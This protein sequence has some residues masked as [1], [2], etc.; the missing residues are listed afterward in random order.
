[1]PDA[2][3]VVA[4]IARGRRLASPGT[5]TRPFSDRA[6][7]A[8]FAILGPDLPGAVVL[9]LCAGSGGGGIEALSRGAG[10]AVF[11]E[12]SAAACRTIRSNLAT[13]GFTGPGA[14]VRQVG[15]LAYLDGPVAT[16]DGPFDLVL[17]DPPYEDRAL[18]AAILE[19]LG[20]D[21]A[22]SLLRTGARVVASHHWRTVPPP[23]IGLLASERERRVGETALTFYRR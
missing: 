21:E 17:V 23:A 7:Q 1:M 22:G 13:T 10:R 9:D 11:V 5:G 3:R 20:R 16:A 6:K 14:L 4:G 19:R 8:L 18:L 2:G 12:R 15:A